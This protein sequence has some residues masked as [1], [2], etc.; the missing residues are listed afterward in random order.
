MAELPAFVWCVGQGGYGVQTAPA[1]GE[2][3]AALVTGTP[4]PLTPGTVAALAPDR[5]RR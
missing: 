5:L 2:L 3:L 1:I 4:P